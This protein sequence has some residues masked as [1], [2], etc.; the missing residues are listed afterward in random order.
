M[1]KT[2][3]DKCKKEIESVDKLIISRYPTNIFAFKDLELDL[4]PKCKND[5][6]NLLKRECNLK[7]EE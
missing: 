2:I 4:C 5:L 6:I 3:C 7:E 1:K